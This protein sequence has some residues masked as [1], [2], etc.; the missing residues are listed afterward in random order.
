[1]TLSDGT[2][3]NCLVGFTDSVCVPVAAHFSAVIGCSPV[4]FTVTFTNLTSI[5]P[6]ETIS[7]YFWDFDGTNTNTSTAVNP[8]YSYASAGNYTVTL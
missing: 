6:G 1:G 2:P 8:V 3:T 5:L 7:G 4:P